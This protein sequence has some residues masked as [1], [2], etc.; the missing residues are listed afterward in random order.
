MFRQQ[1][2][3]DVCFSL[4][5]GACVRSRPCLGRAGLLRQSVCVC[6]LSVHYRCL[7]LQP[8]APICQPAALYRDSWGTFLS[9]DGAIVCATPA[10][11]PPSPCTILPC[12]GCRHRG[13]QG[14]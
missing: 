8:L 14:R 9:S 6:F 11:E 4:A 7:A 1:C 13:C 3:R 12:S 2:S 10:Q 5:G